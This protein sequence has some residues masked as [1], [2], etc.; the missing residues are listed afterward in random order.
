MDEMQSS[1]QTVKPSLFIK[2]YFAYLDF[3]NEIWILKC[4]IWNVHI[5]ILWSHVMDFFYARGWLKENEFR[6]DL[7]M[8]PLAMFVLEGE[9]REAYFNDLARRRQ[10]A[11]L[12]TLD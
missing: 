10:A 2:I 9:Q 7:D 11:H 3:K 8:D 5:K 4:L 6:A 1:K 12:R